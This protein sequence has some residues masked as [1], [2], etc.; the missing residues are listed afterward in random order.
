MATKSDCFSS[1]KGSAT[2]DIAA[3]LGTFGGVGDGGLL[4]PCHATPIG[5]I[6]KVKKV[7]RKYSLTAPPVVEPVITG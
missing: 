2:I 6:L 1:A 7:E 4:K 5:V 3:T